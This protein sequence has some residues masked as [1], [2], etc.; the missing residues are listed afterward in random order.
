MKIPDLLQIPQS[1][2]VMG[3]HDAPH[4]EDGEGPERHI[5]LSAYR[6]SATAVS[7]AEFSEFIQATGYRTA[8]EKRGRSQVFQGR[9]S[10]PDLHLTV[11]STVPWWRWVDG[12]FWAM[13]NGIEHAVMDH[14]VVHVNRADAAAYCAWRRV[15]LPT[16]AEWENAAT[17]QGAVAPHIW[18]GQFPNAPVSPP[19]TRAVQDAVPNAHGLYHSC[20]NVWEW[21]SDRFNR[22]HSPRPD[23][24]PKGALNGQTFVVKGGSYLCSPSYCARFRPSSRRQEVPDATTCHLGFR[25]AV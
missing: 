6:I 10:D 11:S 9:L 3:A 15:R 21:V 23:R 17:P 2:F 18:Q 12:A 5:T 24:N 16:E 4:P 7:N 22:L 20:G 25:V 8:A 14:P 13:P 19:N 1:E